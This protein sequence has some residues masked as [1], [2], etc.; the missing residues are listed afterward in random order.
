[1]YLKFRSS[2]DWWNAGDTREEGIRGEGRLPT[3][4]SDVVVDH[5]R[6]Q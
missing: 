3:I 4:G 6:D 5:A 2:G 1:M